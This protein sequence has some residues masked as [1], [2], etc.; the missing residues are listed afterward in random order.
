MLKINKSVFLLNN[1]HFKFKIPHFA[2]ICGFITNDNLTNCH[3]PLC[4]KTFNDDAG[5]QMSLKGD[6]VPIV[7][8]P[9]LA[10]GMTVLYMGDNGREA[11]EI[12]QCES[13]LLPSPIHKT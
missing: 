9:S 12:R 10:L 1:L 3:N 5:S 13:P 6:W 7:R 11:G 8:D 4:T 2:A